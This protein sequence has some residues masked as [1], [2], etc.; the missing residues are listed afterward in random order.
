MQDKF[1]WALSSCQDKSVPCHRVL[2]RSGKL[3]TNGAFGHVSI[4]KQLLEEEGIFVSD[5]YVV[6]L[7]EYL[8]VP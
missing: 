7:S 4:Q 1:G 3:C 2:N 5:S 8:W 6:D